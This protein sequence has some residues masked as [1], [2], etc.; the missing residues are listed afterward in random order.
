GRARTRQCRPLAAGTVEARAEQRLAAWQRRLR[1]HR[2]WR[3]AGDHPSQG[4]GPAVL[5]SRVR[6]VLASR[7][8]ALAGILLLRLRLSEAT[9]G[10][11]RW[12]LPLASAF[13]CAR[14]RPFCPA[15]R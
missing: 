13:G 9:Q 2:R 6:R 14:S 5:P 10:G 11:G 8:R 1:G 3:G 4:G 15:S 7:L 12:T